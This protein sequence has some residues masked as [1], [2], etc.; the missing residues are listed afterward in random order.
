MAHNAATAL[1]AWNHVWPLPL[2]R[3]LSTTVGLAALTAGVVAYAAGAI[4]MGSV[5][6]MSGQTAD[7]LACD[8]IYRWSR[9]PQQLGAGVALAGIAL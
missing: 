7:R 2:P 4:S 3:A 1:A 6:R 5:A 8:G 9:N